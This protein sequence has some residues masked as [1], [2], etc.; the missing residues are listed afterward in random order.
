MPRESRLVLGTVNFGM[1]YGYLGGASRLTKATAF[2]IMQHSVAENIHYFD[3]AQDYGES[4]EILGQ[5][6]GSNQAPQLNVI[7][8]FR[9]DKC[10]GNPVPESLRK[11]NVRQIYAVLF[12]DFTDYL[13]HPKS[14]RKLQEY[15]SVGQVKKIGFSLYLPRDLEQLLNSKIPFEIVQVPYSIFDRRFDPYFSELKE[16]DVE[17]HVRSIFLNGLFF[18]DPAMLSDHFNSVKGALKEL[19]SLSRELQATRSSLCLNFVYQH[20]LIDKLVVGVRTVDE[21]ITNVGAIS[22]P[23]ELPCFKEVLD[24]FACNDQSI[25]HPHEWRVE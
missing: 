4:E 7:T 2:R 19:K 9:A 13:R 10:N 18:H 20:E 5:Y 1:D 21:L 17:I 12:H 3:T 22:P 11:L 14:F 15:Q 6:I 23:L 16:R 24:G 8:K 25:L